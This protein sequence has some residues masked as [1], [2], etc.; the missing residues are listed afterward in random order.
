MNG[1]STEV[2]VEATALNFSPALQLACD[3]YNYLIA[4]E[5]KSNIE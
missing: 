4:R 2:V 3:L 5:I 1:S